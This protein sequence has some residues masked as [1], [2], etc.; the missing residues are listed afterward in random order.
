[1]KT[2]QENEGGVVT[3][4]PVKAMPSPQ[5][6]VIVSRQDML[7]IFAEKSAQDAYLIQREIAALGF[8]L[9]DCRQAA[10]LSQT[11]LASLAG[12]SRGTVANIELGTLPGGPKIATYSRLMRACGKKVVAHFVDLRADEW[13]RVLQEFPDVPTSGGDNVVAYPGRDAIYPVGV[14]GKGDEAHRV[15]NVA[16]GRRSTRAAGSS[17][18]STG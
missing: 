2:D 15:R 18:S 12:T 3:T 1:M 13:S 14:G 9:R 8:T 16:V 7:A 11:E 4:I 5:A 6:D 17:R 10:G